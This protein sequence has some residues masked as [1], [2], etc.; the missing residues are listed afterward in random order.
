MGSS[1]H[2]PV[3]LGDVMA[4]LAPQAGDVHVDGTFGAGGYSRALLDA[5]AQ[6][7]AID[8]DP[9]VCSF[10]TTLTAQYKGRFHFCAGRY[11]AMRALLAERGISQVQG[12]TLDIGMSS[13]HIDQPE[14]GFSFMA[15]GPLDM[16]MESAGESAADF[17]NNRSETEIADV[18]YLYGEETRSRRIARAIVAAR[19]INRTG[20]LAAVVRKAMGYHPGIKKDPAAQVFQALRIVL[21]DELGELERGLEAAQALLAPQGRI[22]IVCFHSLEDRM[23]KQFLKRR[24]GGVGAGSRH[25]PIMADAGPAPTFSL[26][27]KPVRAHAAELSANPRARSAILRS[28]VRTSAPHVDNQQWGRA[29]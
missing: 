4:A 8:R 28:A 10:A 3:L 23:V 18:I 13:M 15:D 25:L 16:R 12:I 24:S 29:A 21:N 11:S 6:V 19:P 20:E 7:Y 1:A 9:N 26:V 27:A 17:V 22:A 2:I 5:G 14:R